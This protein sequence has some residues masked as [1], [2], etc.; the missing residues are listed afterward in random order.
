VI[1]LE[2]DLE[3]P[4]DVKEFSQEERNSEEKEVGCYKRGGGGG[5]KPRGFPSSSSLIENGG[6]RREKGEFRYF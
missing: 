6:F 2:K 5:E 4:L 1:D 3:K